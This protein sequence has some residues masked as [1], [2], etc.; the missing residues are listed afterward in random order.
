MDRRAA[1]TCSRRRSQVPGPANP[2]KAR[3]RTQSSIAVSANGSDW[4]L[5]NASPDVLQQVRESPGLQPA[6]APRDSGI[7]GMLLAATGGRIMKLGLL[8]LSS[9]IADHIDQAPLADRLGFT[10]YWVAEHQPQPSPTLHA[11]VLGG[12]T[13]RI[14]VGTAGILLHYYPPLRAAHDFHFLERIYPARIDAGFCGGIT[15]QPE[16]QGLLLRAIVAAPPALLRDGGVIAP[17]FDA[18]L[19]ELRA[20]AT[21]ADGRLLELEDRERRRTGLPLGRRRARPP[22]AS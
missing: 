18:A 12:I 8:S 1:T 5:V 6:R 11:A 2:V 4:L 3:A 7:A 13:E 16:L 10:R 17:G 22:S 21:G 20:I 9:E 15:P 19:D 14:R